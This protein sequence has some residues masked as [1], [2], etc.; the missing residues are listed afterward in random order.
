MACIYGRILKLM[1]LDLFPCKNEIN[2]DQESHYWSLLMLS[3]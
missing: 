1:G 2:K 3:I